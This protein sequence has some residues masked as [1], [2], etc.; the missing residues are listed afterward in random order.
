MI[1]S[2]IACNGRYTA[3]SGAFAYDSGGLHGGPGRAHV[4]GPYPSYA[5]ARP[6]RN[7]PH[8]CPC[9]SLLLMMISC[10]VYRYFL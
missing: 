7:L 8:A 2:R 9:V 4:R 6:L 10:T 5:P 3:A 1:F